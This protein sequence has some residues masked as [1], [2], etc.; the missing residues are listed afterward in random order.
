MGF[1]S[2]LALGKVYEQLAI[3]YLKQKGEALLDYPE[4]YCKQYDFITD[5]SSYEVK[6][7][8][9]THKTGNLFIEY[10]CSGKP[11]GLSTTDAKY[12]FYFILMPENGYR[13]YKIPTEFLKG[14]AEAGR[15]VN[16]GDGWRSK[17]YLCNESW[18]RGYE[19]IASFATQSNAADESEPLREPL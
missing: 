12:W 3:K 8:R 11:S 6:A 18:F 5:K 14:V 10:E 2:D 1:Q 13:A 16:G 7:D 9:M 4:G 15:T 19:A 17:G